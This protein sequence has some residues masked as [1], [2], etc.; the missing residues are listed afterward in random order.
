MS[1]FKVIVVGGGPIGLTAAHT[2]SKAGIDFVL[3]ERRASIIE[4]VGASLVLSPQ[5][6]RVLFQLGLLDSYRRIGQEVLHNVHYT[7]DGKRFRESW[8]LKH[9]NDNNGAYP[10]VCH[11]A[12]FTRL[13]YEALT[14]TDAS[15]VHANKKVCDIIQMETGVRVMCEDGS[16]YQGSIVL[17][18]DGV[19]SITRRIMHQQNPI[20]TSKKPHQNLQNPFST[21]Y[22]VL[23]CALPRLWEYAPGDFIVTHGDGSALQILVGSTKSWFFLYERLDKT[24]PQSSYTSYSEQDAEAYIAKYADAPFGDKLKLGEVWKR[25]LSYGMADLEEGILNKWSNGRIVLAGDAAHK[26]TPNAGLGYNSGLQDVV[27]LV[28]RLHKCLQEGKLDEPDTAEIAKLFKDYQDA[29]TPRTKSDMGASAATTRMCAWPNNFWWF[30]DMYVTTAIPYFE[31]IWFRYVVAPDIS[32]GL[33]LDF[34]RGPEPFVG[35]IPWVNPIKPQVKGSE[36]V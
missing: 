4:D 29:R 15:R 27:E 34:L 16:E 32:R 35:K 21:E 9:L 11:R 6:M 17:G 2:L 23:F 12:D 30:L 31:P 28:N 3:L 1:E 36:M 13:L 18:A 22:K 19:H 14:P 10:S 8:S 5:I 7:M 20:D 33:V 24:K 26:F 25:K